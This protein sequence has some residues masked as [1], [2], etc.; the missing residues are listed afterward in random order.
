MT[1]VLFSHSS[2][3]LFLLFIRQQ[4]KRDRY[5]IPMKESRLYTTGPGGINLPPSILSLSR[6]T[7]KMDGHL[8]QSSRRTDRNAFQN[9]SLGFISCLHEAWSVPG[10]STW[11]RWWQRCERKWALS[12]WGWSDPAPKLMGHNLSE[13]RKKKQ[14]AFIPKYRCHFCSNHVIKKKNIQKCKLKIKA[15]NLWVKSPAG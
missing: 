15:M 10:S 12:L 2:C 5:F 6:S 11:H 9:G 3:S 13:K 1:G 8:T 14:Q 7:C 4:Q